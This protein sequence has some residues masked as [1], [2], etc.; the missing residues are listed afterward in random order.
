M[1]KFLQTKYFHFS[2]DYDISLGYQRKSPYRVRVSSQLNIA[3]LKQTNNIESF[4]IP[5][6][7]RSRDPIKNIGV[8]VKEKRKFSESSVCEIIEF[9]SG[10]NHK[11]KILDKRKRNLIDDFYTRRKISRASQ[12][13][14]IQRMKENNDALEYFEGFEESCENQ[15][16]AGTY[17][18]LRQCINEKNSKNSKS[19][20]VASKK[21]T[22]MKNIK[23]EVSNCVSVQTDELII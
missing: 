14:S 10:L 3:R 6:I 15:S 17:K 7:R 23:P 8:G 20:I 12:D 11:A 9:S 18:Y 21:I 22:P 16:I 19:I 5:Y 1:S 13:K 2:K 4:E